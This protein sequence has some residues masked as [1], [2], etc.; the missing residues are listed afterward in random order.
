MIYF[1]YGSN[2]SSTVMAKRCPGAASLGVARLDHHRLTFDLPSR[3]WGGHAANVVPDTSS[4][5][6]G[7]LWNVTEGH[8]TSLDSVEARYDRYPI[9]VTQNDSD[10]MAMT[11]KVKE[12]LVSPKGGSPHPTYVANILEGAIE[13]GLP[14]NYVRSI[15]AR[16]LEPRT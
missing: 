2:M 6:W 14:E 8:L 3:R 12:S 10:I 4:G 1:G 15:R 7:V 9:V 5:V 16:Y 11:Y 13:H